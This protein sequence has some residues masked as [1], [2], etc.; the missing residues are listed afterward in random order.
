MYND[1]IS[2]H[3]LKVFKNIKLFYIDLMKVSSDPFSF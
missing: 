2:K 3:Y 1:I